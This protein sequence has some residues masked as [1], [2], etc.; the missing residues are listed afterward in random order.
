MWDWDAIH[1]APEL[2]RAKLYKAIAKQNG[3]DPIEDLTR[4]EKL[5]DEFVASLAGVNKKS[6]FDTN[7]NVTIPLTKNF[8]KKRMLVD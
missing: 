4:V 2:F 5:G 8:E 1:K 6:I 3:L 7:N